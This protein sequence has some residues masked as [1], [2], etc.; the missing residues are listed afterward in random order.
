MLCFSYVAH[1]A[2]AAVL[3]RYIT[4]LNNKIQVQ[5]DLEQTCQ[6][7]ALHELKEGHDGAVVVLLY[8]IDVFLQGHYELPCASQTGVA[9]GALKLRGKVVLINHYF[10]LATPLDSFANVFFDQYLVSQDV[11]LL[12]ASILLLFFFLLLI[13]PPQLCQLKPARFI[14]AE[15][16]PRT[17]IET[18]DTIQHVLVTY[19]LF[20]HQNE[21]G[22]EPFQLLDSLFK[23]LVPVNLLFVDGNYIVSQ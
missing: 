19:F 7:L 8:R 16:R 6:C 23:L 18:A 12:E 3:V 14:L 11:E 20:R 5:R 10:L 2:K 4:S 17:T 1:V 9:I 22:I 21:L 13:S 15:T